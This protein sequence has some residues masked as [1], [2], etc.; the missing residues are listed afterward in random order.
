MTL[1]ASDPRVVRLPP[2]WV[3]N[4]TMPADDDS[5]PEAF[6][7][8]ASEH[9]QH[10]PDYWAAFRA[11]IRERGV[12]TPIIVLIGH[13]ERPLLISGHHRLR[14][15]LRENLPSIPLYVTDDAEEAYDLA[16][17]QA[18]AEEDWTTWEA[19]A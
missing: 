2:Q 15:A 4:N 1:T 12:L 7:Y 5:W 16:D 3:L 6:A 19:A 11:S 14:D 17:G 18:E 13:R 10:Q 9:E 8:I